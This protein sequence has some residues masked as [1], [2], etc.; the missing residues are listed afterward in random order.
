MKRMMTR[1]VFVLGLVLLVML[2]MTG[3]AYGLWSKTLHIEGTVFTGEL[4]AVYDIVEIDDGGSVGDGVWDELE[5]E[6]KDVGYC[7]AFLFDGGVFP[8]LDNPGPQGMF[9]EIG[10]AY[11]SFNC[12]VV[13]AITNVGSIPWKIAAPQ[14]S[15]DGMAWTSGLYAIDTPYMHVNGWPL[16]SLG[17]WGSSYE[18]E[19]QVHPGETVYASLHF[20]LEQGAEM[21]AT[22]GFFVRHFVHQWNE[23]CGDP[24]FPTEFCP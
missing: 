4:N 21:N 14:Y 19:A 9:V 6:G 15:E 23:N 18:P 13:Y 16:G 24:G 12:F 1:P 20:H 5:F 11:P 22:Y 3:V 10:N 8:D 17:V 2:A 7:E